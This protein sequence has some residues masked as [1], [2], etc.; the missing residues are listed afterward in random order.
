MKSMS[1]LKYHFG[2]KMQAYP[3]KKQ[4]KIIDLNINVQRRVYNCMVALGREIYD[5]K[6][7]KGVYI[8]QNMLRL[9][10]L[11]KQRKQQAYLAN[12]HP[13]L[14][15]KKIDSNAVSQAKRNYQTAWKN[16]RTVPNAQMPHFKKWGYDGSYQTSAVYNKNPMSPFVASVRFI[17]LK[18]VK[19]PKVGKVAVCGS[20][21]RIL[22]NKTDIKIGTTT[23]KRDN[24]GDYY[25]SMQLGSD[26]PFVKE[27]PPVDFDHQELGIDL[28]TRNFLE[29][30]DGLM[31]DNPHFL[32]KSIKRLRKEMRVLSRRQQV[33]KKQ[34]KPLRKA[35]NYQKQRKVVA[36]IYR[37]LTNQRKDFINNVA[38]YLTK[39]YGMVAAEDLKSRTMLGKSHKL[40]QAIYEVSWYAFLQRMTTNAELYNRKFVKVNPA[41][42][43]QMCSNCGHV[44][45][46]DGTSKLHF[47][48]DNPRKIWVCPKCGAKH[49]SDWNAAI[50]ILARAKLML[51]DDE[52]TA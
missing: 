14:Y 45:G 18:T 28:N 48:K 4:R 30:S 13:W 39:N 23:V 9:P 33:A 25:I 12:A 21:E 27:L 24:C 41:N 8:R 15:N 47:G 42:T 38:A 1:E 40:N 2:L 29:T 50:N 6:H 32:L 7:V 11:E 3:T 5:I 35:K 22:K 51:E 26:T 19:L 37:H 44:M 17:D 10:E 16:Y 34:H 31:I 49:E 46:E 20:Q 43:T 36:K 52:V